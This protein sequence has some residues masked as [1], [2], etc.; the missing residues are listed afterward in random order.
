[1]LKGHEEYGDWAVCGGHLSPMSPSAS[2]HGRQCR[3]RAQYGMLGSGQRNVA[4]LHRWQQRS[5]DGRE[6]LKRTLDRLG[7]GSAQP[8]HG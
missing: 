4:N 8:M 1:M 3:P 7:R 6:G 5:G 2:V